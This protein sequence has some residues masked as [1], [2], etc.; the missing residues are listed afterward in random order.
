MRRRVLELSARLSV[1]E[2]KALAWVQK[3]YG[4]PLDALGAEQVA[5]AVRSLADELNR[6]NGVPAGGRPNRRR[7]A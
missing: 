3:R 1:D 6:R 5:D 2:D 7:A 4:Q